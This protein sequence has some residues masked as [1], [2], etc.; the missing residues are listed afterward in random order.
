MKSDESQAAITVDFHLGLTYSEILYALAVNHGIIVSLPTLKRLLK[1]PPDNFKWWPP[2]N[3]KW[4][5]PDT[6]K[7]RPPDNF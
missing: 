5:A 4:P 1:R 7:W 6:F 2:D 3:F